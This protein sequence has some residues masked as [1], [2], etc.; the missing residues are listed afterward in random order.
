MTDSKMGLGI[1]AFSFEVRDIETSSQ[2]EYCKADC[3]ANG[4]S[5]NSFV[6]LYMS[7]LPVLLFLSEVNLAV[8]LVFEQ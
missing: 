4:S 3:I 2:R 1:E 5:R 7:L 8:F 6:R